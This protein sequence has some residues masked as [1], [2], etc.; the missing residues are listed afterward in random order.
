MLR[1][2]LRVGLAMLA[3]SVMLAMS[4]RAFGA[5]RP[6]HPALVGF[7]QNCPD[8]QSSCWYGIVPGLTNEIDALNQMQQAGSRQVYPTPR[9]PDY[10]YFSL[11]APYSACIAA[12]RVEDEIVREGRILICNAANM[13]LGD[14]LAVWGWEQDMLSTPP[15]DLTYQMVSINADGWPQPYTR[16]SNINLLGDSHES[17]RFRW[18]GFVPRWRYCQLEPRY[19]RCR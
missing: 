8:E 18:H 19:P 10:L 11:P 9:N 16:V 4:A 5:S 7:Y 2:A 17:P 12:F 14:V 13:R 15:H 3:I 1:L 6:P